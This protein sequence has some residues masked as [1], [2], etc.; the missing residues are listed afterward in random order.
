MSGSHY[1]GKIWSPMALFDL[2]HIQPADIDNVLST[3]LRQTVRSLVGVRMEGLPS[4]CLLMSTAWYW[5]L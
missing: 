2:F 4:T 3:A 1:S 5:V